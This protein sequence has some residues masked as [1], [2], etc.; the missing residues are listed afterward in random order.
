M[1]LEG[2]DI[3]ILFR[4]WATQGINID[5]LEPAFAGALCRG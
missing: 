5:G 4:T 2:V 1:D 3:G